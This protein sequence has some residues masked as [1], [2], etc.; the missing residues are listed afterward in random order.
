[1]EIVVRENW[2]TQKLSSLDLLKAALATSLLFIGSLLYWNESLG[3]TELMSANGTQVFENHQYWRLW[4]TLLAHGDFRHLLS[5]AA[6]FLVLGTF[7]TGYFGSWVFPLTAMAFGGMVN[8]FVLQSMPPGVAVIG[9]SGVVYWMGGFWLTLY[10]LLDSRRRLSQRLLRAGGVSLGIFMPT[11]AFDPT[12][13]YSSHFIGFFFGIAFG[14][15]YYAWR[16][17]E[18]QSAEVRE[19]LWEEEA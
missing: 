16:R 14:L 10:L 5:N 1:M 18:F 2:L 11:E 17:P 15:L 6:L 12:I 19:I 9:A 7:L 8:H 3:V 4:T 13:S